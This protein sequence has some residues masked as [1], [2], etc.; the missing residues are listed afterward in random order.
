[1]VNLSDFTFDMPNE[2]PSGEQTWELRNTGDQWPEMVLFK[3]Q[4]G[5]TEEDLVQMLMSDQQP[6]GPPPFEGAGYFG[7]VSNG[8]SFWVPLD[9]EPGT[10]AAVCFLPDLADPA[11]GKSHVEEGMVKTFQV[12]GP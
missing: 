3:L 4:E 10:Y 7:P 5:T 8:D 2:V 6:Q 11:S 9:L 1:M 12:T